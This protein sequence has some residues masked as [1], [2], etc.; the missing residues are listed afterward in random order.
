MTDIS[1][2]FLYTLIAGDIARAN[3]TL[4]L[5]GTAGRALTIETARNA[6]LAE[7]QDASDAD[8]SAALDFARDNKGT[9]SPALT[10][11]ED[12]LLRRLDCGPEYLADVAAHADANR[13][14]MGAI[15]IG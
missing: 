12:E 13:R 8:L 14:A 5:I 4:R 9:E 2:H 10:V 7:L 3:R 15:T 11:L 6:A 1:P